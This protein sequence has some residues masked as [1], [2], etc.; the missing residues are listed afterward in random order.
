VAREYNSAPAYRGGGDYRY[1]GGGNRYSFGF[2]Y[3]APYYYPSYDYGYYNAPACG[4]YDRWGYW[5]YTPGCYY[6]PAW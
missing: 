5:R 4:Y 3:G 1:R 6:G 2:G